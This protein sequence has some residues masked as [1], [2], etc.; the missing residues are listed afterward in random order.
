MP[1]RWTLTLTAETPIRPAT[2]AQLHG[3]ACTLFEGTGA[4]HTSQHKPFTVSPLLNGPDPHTADLCL[5]WLDDTHPPPPTLP[6][7][8]RIRLGSQSLTIHHT[9]F[10]PAPYHALLNTPPTRRADITF[11]SPT[12]FTDAGRSIPLPDPRLV[13]QSLLR[14]WNHHAP[15]PVPE[16]SA[17]SLFDSLLLTAH[18]T[19]T[20]TVTLGPGRRTGFT[21]TATYALHRHADT[22]TL[23]TF[24]A[25]THFA[26]VAGIGAQTTHAQGYVRVSPHHP[27]ERAPTAQQPRHHDR[28]P[29]QTRA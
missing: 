23:H 4:D 15:R 19:A 27:R 6:T 13:Y 18:D 7:T 2:P 8:H 5:G 12:H 21:G 20:T 25:L 1:A 22:A 26:A 17:A 9:D 14:R 16:S 28:D 3:L 29:R 10:E 11:L 24:T